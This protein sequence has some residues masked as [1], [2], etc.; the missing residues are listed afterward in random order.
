MPLSGSPSGR[1][2]QVQPGRETSA[3]GPGL[4][5]A[6]LLRMRGHWEEAEAECAAVIRRQPDDPTAHSLLGDI[7]LDQGRIADAE[8]WYQLALDIDP[9]RVADRRRLQRAGELL[10]ARRTRSD[11]EEALRT[12]QANVAGPLLLREA[13]QRVAAIVGFG[14]CAVILVMAALVAANERKTGLDSGPA[15]PPAARAAPLIQIETSHERAMLRMLVGELAG[16]P[17]Q[18]AR[19][20]EGINPRSLDLRLYAPRRLRETL[21]AVEYRSVLLREAYRAARAALKFD[22]TL[23]TIDVTIVGSIFAPTGGW[24]TERVFRGVA[25][26]EDLVVEADRATPAEV[27]GAFAQV[28]APFWHLDLQLAQP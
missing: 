11:W 15:A 16:R 3:G 5:R 17:L 24:G 8:R 21:P 26:A 10:A 4:A 22:P 7:Y 28:E 6:N 1:P 20:E 14:A 13:V 2:P 25:T 19:V 12:G 23:E 27:A 18:A 9:G